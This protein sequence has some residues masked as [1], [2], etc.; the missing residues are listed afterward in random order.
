MAAAKDI[1]S[2]LASE[3]AD[4]GIS[5]SATMPPAASFSQAAAGW[6]T[7][8]SPEA[9]AKFQSHFSVWSG[10]TGPGDILYTP[11]GFVV[12]HRVHNDKDN[13]GIKVGLLVP[14]DLSSLPFAVEGMATAGKISNSTV[15]ALDFIKRVLKWQLMAEGE[16]K[17]SASAVPEDTAEKKDKGEVDSHHDHMAE[18]KAKGSAS[19]VP[20][21]TAENE[22]PL[23]ETKPAAKVVD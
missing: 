4:Q 16:K 2:F 20:E 23:G 17:G 14:R 10:T 22:K 19:A 5:S 9:L 12:A 11:S 13:F 3:K 6:L 1:A 7:N 21:E 18:G 15:Q 8:A